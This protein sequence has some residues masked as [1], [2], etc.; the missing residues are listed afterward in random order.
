M[1]YDFFSKS[2]YENL[3][4]PRKNSGRQRC[5]EGFNSG[6]KR[7]NRLKFNVCFAQAP[8]APEPWNKIRHATTDGSACAQRNDFTRVL[9]G[10]DD[11]LFLNVYTPKVRHMSELCTIFVNCKGSG[12]QRRNLTR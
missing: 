8:E 5:S 9:L 7:V 2:M 3:K 4:S 12:K 1:R 10:E 11:C 6:V